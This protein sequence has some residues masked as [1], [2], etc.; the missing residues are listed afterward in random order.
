MQYVI[1]RVFTL[2]VSYY[3]SSDNDSDMERTSYRGGSGPG[4]GYYYLVMT[5]LLFIA[6]VVGIMIQY[7]GSEVATVFWTALGIVVV[8][9]L[10]GAM[11]MAAKYAY[12]FMTSGSHGRQTAILFEFVLIAL[13][14]IVQLALGALALAG[15]T[16]SLFGVG[17]VKN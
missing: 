13:V 1:A 16:R 12:S 8:L 11:I 3:S 6:L 9:M 5:A 4:A 17:K 10:L 2:M 7:F 14:I 15:S